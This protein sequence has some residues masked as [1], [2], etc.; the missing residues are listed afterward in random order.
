MTVSINPRS[1]EVLGISAR[2]W[3]MTCKMR[4][5]GIARIVFEPEREAPVDLAFGLE[6]R[7]APAS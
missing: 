7:F 4:A 3:W 1:T 5:S 6:E 2:R